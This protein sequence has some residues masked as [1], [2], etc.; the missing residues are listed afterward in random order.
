[1]KFR[2]PG[3]Q[4]NKD[5]SVE[6]NLKRQRPEDRRTHSVK[7]SKVRKRKVKSDEVIS[8]QVV[9]KL[10]YLYLSRYDLK[11]KVNRRSKM[12]MRVGKPTKMTEE[13]AMS[14]TICMQ[15][16]QIKTRGAAENPRR[17]VVCSDSKSL[18][19]SL[20]STKQVSEGPLRPNIKQLKD[21]RDHGE[22]TEFKGG[23]PD[24]AEGG[25]CHPGESS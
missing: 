2:S 17:M 5:K 8:K 4:N 3:V 9:G 10:F 12:I 7:V 1:M 15:L 24:Q 25:P 20:S 14:M 13:N 21:F 18:T 6:D 19:E 22:V 11:F 16:N 23:R